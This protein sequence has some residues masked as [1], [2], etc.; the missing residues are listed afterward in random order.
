MVPFGATA[1]ATL[2]P[3][4]CDPHWVVPGTASGDG[5][6]GRV[7]SSNWTLHVVSV[8]AGAPGVRTEKETLEA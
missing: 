8:P 7:L 3:G 2:R 6:H 5:G 4:R 1:G